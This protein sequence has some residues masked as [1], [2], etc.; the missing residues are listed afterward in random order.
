AHAGFAERRKQLHNS[1]AHHLQA[2]R[3]VIASWLDE[4]AIDPT[5]RA[6]TLSVDEW[7]RLTRVAQARPR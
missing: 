7:V 2:P 1:L 6:E 5:R 3:E 4:A